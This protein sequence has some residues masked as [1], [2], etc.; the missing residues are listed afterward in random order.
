MKKLMMMMM[1]M[2]MM[3]MT[4]KMV[5]MNIWSLQCCV[6]QPALKVTKAIVVVAAV[7]TTTRLVNS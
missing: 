2:A 6:I 3:V 5:T 1:T 4:T 7:S